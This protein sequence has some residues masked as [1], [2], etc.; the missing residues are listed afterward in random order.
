[1]SHTRAVGTPLA[2]MC[3]ADFLAWVI[4]GEAVELCNKFKLRLSLKFERRN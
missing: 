1:M 4:L 2:G 3:T